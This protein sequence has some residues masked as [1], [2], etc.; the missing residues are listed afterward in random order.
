MKHERK[1]IQ[2]P[3]EGGAIMTWIASATSYSSQ[4]APTLPFL[5]YYS[6]LYSCT[7][8]LSSLFTAGASSILIWCLHCFGYQGL[9]FNV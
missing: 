6:M 9:D 8:T 1:C 2:H 7:N 3:G 4:H 5:I